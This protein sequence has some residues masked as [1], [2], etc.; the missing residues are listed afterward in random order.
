[1]TTTNERGRQLEE[2]MDP[3]I[4]QSL[5]QTAITIGLIFAGRIILWILMAGLGL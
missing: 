1:M 2:T 5:K 3:E 4:H